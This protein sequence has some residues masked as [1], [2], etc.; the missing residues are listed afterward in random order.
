MVQQSLHTAISMNKTEIPD[1]ALDDFSE[2]S[3]GF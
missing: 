1:G 3:Q 2:V